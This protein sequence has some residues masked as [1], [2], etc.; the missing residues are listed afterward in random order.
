MVWKILLGVLLFLVILK[1]GDI[2]AIIARFI[3]VRGNSDSWKKW[4]NIA[5]MLGGMSFESKL[6]QAYLL[7]KDGN[8][9]T[10]YKKFALLSMDNLKS[11]QKLRLKASY[12]LVFWK[13]G[14]ISTA[15]EMLEEVAEKAPSTPVYGS[16]GY[17]YAYSG[18]LSAALEFNKKAYDYNNTDPIIIDNLAYTYHK[19]G[20]YNKAREYYEK[21]MKLS[22]NFPEAYYGFGRLLVET[23]ELEK[24]VEMLK[25]ALNTQFSFLSTVTKS[26]IEAYLQEVNKDNF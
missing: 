3:Y 10:A 19:V 1:R 12:A 22:P 14:E 11:D 13:R 2:A 21:L 9:D 8:L 5:E 16:L 24:G 7:L 25:K 17:M 18:N 6:T 26:E 15:I 20:E 23:G 4:Y